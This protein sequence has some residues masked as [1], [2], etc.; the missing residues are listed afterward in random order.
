MRFTLTQLCRVLH[1]EYNPVS[2]KEC[3]NG[4]ISQFNL[5]LQFANQDIEIG[6]YEAYTDCTYNFVDIVR[7]AVVHVSVGV[8]PQLGGTVHG[9]GE[10]GDRGDA[11]YVVADVLCEDRGVFFLQFSSTFYAR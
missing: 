1:G 11:Q 7:I 6:I 4:G 2:V 10:R 9:S 3:L 5:Q 8:E